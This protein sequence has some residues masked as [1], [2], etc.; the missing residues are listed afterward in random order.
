[1]ADDSSIVGCAQVFLVGYCHAFR[2]C[3]GGKHVE[4]REDSKSPHE[5]ALEFISLDAHKGAGAPSQ[6]KT[7]T[8]RH[9]LRNYENWALVAAVTASVRR[10]DGDSLKAS[11]WSVKRLQ[12]FESKRRFRLVS[13]SAVAGPSA[14]QR[15]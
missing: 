9:Q 2:F 11:G 15:W 6:N 13:V 3:P 4:Y 7:R 8:R 1:M 12:T 10:I 14:A 5:G